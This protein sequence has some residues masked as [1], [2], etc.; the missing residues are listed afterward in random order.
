MDAV[1]ALIY[2]AAPESAYVD[3]VADHHSPALCSKYGFEPVVPKSL[4]MALST[5]RLDLKA[6]CH[7]AARLI[8]FPK[9]APMTH[10]IRQ[11]AP[12]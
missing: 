1:M 8:I 7:L 2:E 9:T 10:P 6:S 4:G 11:A 12:P 5:K 3:L